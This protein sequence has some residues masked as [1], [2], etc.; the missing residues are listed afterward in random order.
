MVH[1]CQISKISKGDDSRKAP[2]PYDNRLKKKKPCCT[3]KY[4]ITIVH[5]AR[6]IYPIN[7]PNC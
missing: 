4:K 7:Y 3:V 2:D 6:A 1:I 5:D